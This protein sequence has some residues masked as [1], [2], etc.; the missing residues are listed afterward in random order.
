MLDAKEEIKNILAQKSP[1]KHSRLS[2]A[3]IKIA[4][5]QRER[6]IKKFNEIKVE[7]ETELSSDTLIRNHIGKL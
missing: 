2:E 7:Y 3:I 5:A 4:D 1:I 6:S